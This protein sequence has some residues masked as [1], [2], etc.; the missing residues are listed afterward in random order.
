MP[1]LWIIWIYLASV[2][3]PGAAVEETLTFDIHKGGKAV[4]ELTATKQ[5]IYDR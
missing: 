5:V 2:L 1:S 3:S 4:G